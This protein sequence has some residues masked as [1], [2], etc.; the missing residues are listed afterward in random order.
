MW[1]IDTI[2]W[3]SSF[4]V[5]AIML[6]DMRSHRH[7]GPW[8][9]NTHHQVPWT[10]TSMLCLPT[11][12]Q[13]A[14]WRRCYTS[15]VKTPTPTTA[16]VCWRLKFINELQCV[17]MASVCHSVSVHSVTDVVI[18]LILPLQMF[19]CWWT[20]LCQLI[21]LAMSDHFVNFWYSFV[22]LLRI[23]QDCCDQEG[24]RPNTALMLQISCG[25][26][27]DMT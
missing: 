3:Q 7:G 21:V 16:P 13:S 4:L 2:C 6:L 23:V 18:Q 11:W 10:Q 5:N 24:H 14:R 25:L 1:N 9:S 19:L 22:L 15:A 26:Q 8:Y 20:H 17:T 27:V 12:P